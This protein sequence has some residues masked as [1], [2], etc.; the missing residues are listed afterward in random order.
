M[1]QIFAELGLGVAF[2]LV[3]LILFNV[4]VLEHFTDHDQ[5][6]LAPMVPDWLKRNDGPTISVKIMAGIPSLTP[7]EM[8]DSKKMQD[9]YNRLSFGGST[10]KS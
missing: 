1:A 2:T 9:A 8:G 6:A 5:I 3:R 7:E 10:R 4:V